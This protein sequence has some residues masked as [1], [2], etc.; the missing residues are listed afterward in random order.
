LKHA[1]LILED[2]HEALPSSYDRQRI[3][4]AYDEAIEA[5]Q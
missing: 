3:R 2:G 1:E 5:A 4:Q